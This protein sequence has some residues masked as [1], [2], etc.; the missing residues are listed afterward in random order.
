MYRIGWFSTGRGQGSLNLLNAITAA[1]N[2]G[3]VN[4]ELAYVFCSRELGDAEGSDRYIQQVR[5]YGIPLIC[6]SSKRFRPELRKEGK[7]KPE[8]LARWRTEYDREIMSRIA[9]HRVDLIVLAGYMLIVSPEMC[10]RYTMLNLHPAAPNGP[11]GTWQEVIWQLIEQRATHSGNMMHLVIEE[12][13][14]GP[15]VTYS[16]FRLRGGGFDPLWEELEAKLKQT[17][18]ENIIQQEGEKNP[19]FAKIR[20]EGA[21]REIPLVIHTVKAFADGK[22]KIH[23]R[24]IITADGTVLREPYCLTDAIEQDIR[25]T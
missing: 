1:I 18:L 14:K 13:D 15:P 17:T 19:L 23:N 8:L 10:T 2:S 7:H 12:L 22:I 16:T 20:Q 24:Q 11:A 4:A 3:T 6:F 21:R 5:Q 9:P 25:D